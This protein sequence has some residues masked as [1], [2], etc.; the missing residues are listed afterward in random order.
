MSDAMEYEREGE[1]VEP[2]LLFLQGTKT[3]MFRIYKANM[4]FYELLLFAGG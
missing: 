2:V 1:Q 4:E 3:S